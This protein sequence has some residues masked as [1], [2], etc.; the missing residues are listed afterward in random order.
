MSSPRP[1]PLPTSFVVKKRLERARARRAAS[2]IKC[3][4]RRRRRARRRSAPILEA[5][6][7]PPWVGAP[8]RPGRVTDGRMG[9]AECPRTSGAYGGAFSAP[10]HFERRLF[11]AQ[12][13]A[14]GERRVV[15]AVAY[16]DGLLGG[17]G[18]PG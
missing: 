6:P 11:R 4:R 3:R 13:P 14:V 16:V 9:C 18:R 8:V 10:G 2:R 1:V 5:R 15:V 17:A 12:P 7:R